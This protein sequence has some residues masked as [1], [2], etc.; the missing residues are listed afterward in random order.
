[1]KFIFQSPALEI[2]A[3]VLNDKT[4]GYQV[5]QS[6]G[7]CVYLNRIFNIPSLP[8]NQADMSSSQ[9]FSNGNPR[10]QHASHPMASGYRGAPSGPVRYPNPTGPAG[11]HLG[12]GP[13]HLAN[14]ML[15]Q[16]GRR[17]Q[18]LP[19]GYQEAH[20]NSGHPLQAQMNPLTHPM[21][22]HHTGHQ[23]HQLSG[24][25]SHNIKANFPSQ[26]SPP[27]TS[28][29]S[30]PP[31]ST[32]KPSNQAKD[33]HGKKS[34]A[35]SAQPERKTIQNFFE[36]YAALNNEEYAKMT[37]CSFCQ[38]KFR[39][40]SVLLDHLQTHTVNVENIVEMKLKIWVNGRKLKCSELG[41]K[42]KYAY[43]LEYTK[44]KDSHHYEGLKC[45]VCNTKQAGPADYAA[46]I[47]RAN[48]PYDSTILLL[49]T[50]ALN[51]YILII[52]CLS[53]SPCN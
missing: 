46:H 19:M 2:K 26:V 53:Y 28:N 21:S 8:S 22:V 36:L 14:A 44:H 42:K 18:T 13:S 6:N 39:F 47:K 48:S 1:M 52:Y 41:C 45:G 30:L 23:E 17:P 25:D 37:T 15:Q 5:L 29:S 33:D 40:T 27:S 3:P 35:S 20:T 12:Q 51:D 24:A 43:T 34:S 10:S 32:L 16:Q 7:A 4:V 11:P 9:R 38:R 31:I 49:T 50:C